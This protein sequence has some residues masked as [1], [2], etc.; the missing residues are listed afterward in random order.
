MP[1]AGGQTRW[2]GEKEWSPPLDECVAAAAKLILD[3]SLT[4]SN[5]MDL[6]TPMSLL[7]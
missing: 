7:N 1:Q 3:V 5:S 6:I 4:C 2:P